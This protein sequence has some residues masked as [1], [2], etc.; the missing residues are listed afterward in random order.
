MRKLI[1]VQNKSTRVISIFDTTI[2]E[3]N[4][5]NQIIMDAIKT[6]LN[7]M[8]GDY[9][10]YRLPYQQINRSIKSCIDESE[11]VFFGGT[12]SLSS[13]MNKYKQWDI[14]LLKASYV[15]DVIM[16]G[17]G[18]WQYQEKP[19]L[20]TRTLLNKVLS[21][22]Y[23]HS[24]RD[25]Y[26]KNMLE[27][28]GFKTIN[29]GCPTTWGLT[30]E[31]TRQISGKRKMKSV[32]ITLT[33]YNKSKEFDLELLKI[34]QNNYSNIYF[35]PQGVGD[36]EYILSLKLNENNIWVLDSNLE[37]FNEILKNEE[38]DY[39]GT[40]LHAG[41]RALQF[42]RRSFIVAID[43]RAKEIGND[44]NLKV[45]E[46]NNLKMLEQDL[47]NEYKLDLNINWTGIKN[48]K[49]QFITN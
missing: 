42:A 29:T 28:V 18:W 44:I 35:W 32:V 34:C 7:S 14:N 41:I 48:W 45:Y 1:D 25:S 39:V 30:E 11:Y 33:D 16:M 5:G 26:T 22:N 9:F 15:K 4:L 3:Y 17:I 31:L 19:N 21:H 38:V 6:E 27:S 40:R 23:A 43:N 37:S 24:V 46:R 49:K 10:E 36:L 8:F 13:F 2:S 20:Y 12:N 47:N